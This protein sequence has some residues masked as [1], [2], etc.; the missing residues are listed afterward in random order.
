MHRHD[1]AMPR[2][3][4]NETQKKLVQESWAKVVPI[5]EQAADIFYG[6]LFEADPALR[7]LFKGDMKAQ[8]KK[9]MQMIS[10][11]VAG[12]DRLGDIVPA[13]QA[14]GKRHVGYG[15]QDSHYDT[16][17]GALLDTLS[18][19]L[20]PAFTPEVKDAWVVVYGVLSTTMKDA[21]KAG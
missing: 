18:V 12:L 4:M 14:L 19:G 15:V 6:K 10:V 9:L 2:N 3:L 21:A 20:G 5:A 17:G 7:A 13:V 8:G 16:V 1:A 11:A